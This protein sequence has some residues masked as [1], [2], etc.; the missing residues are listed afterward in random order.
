MTSQTLSF[1]RLDSN[2]H[3]RLTTTS[4]ASWSPKIWRLETWGLGD[5]EDACQGWRQPLFIGEGRVEATPLTRH[6]SICFS[7]L[8]LGWT[9][10]A[11][12]LRWMTLHNFTS[13]AWLT[14]VVCLMA[15]KSQQNLGI[16][17]IN[18]LLNVFDDILPWNIKC[19]KNCMSAWVFL[20]I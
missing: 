6:Q 16:E 13:V 14:I 19:Q 17:C 9:D 2:S 1:A 15:V 11:N 8:A 7:T 5:L 18:K 10:L 4:L 20:K 3:S 12:H